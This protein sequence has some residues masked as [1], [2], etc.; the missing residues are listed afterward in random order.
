VNLSSVL[1]AATTVVVL[2]AIIQ[3]LTNDRS[4]SALGALSFAFSYSFWSQAVE[5]EVYALN[6]LFVSTICYLLLRTFAR[7][8]NDPSFHRASVGGRRWVRWSSALVAVPRGQLT[9]I[10]VALVYGLSLTHHRTMLLL[11]PAII[12]YL[13]VRGAWRLMTSRSSTVA[14]VAFLAPLVTIHLYIPIRWWQINGEGMHWKQF[15]DLVLGTQFAAALRWDTIFTDPNRLHIFLRTLLD[16]YPAP[17]LLLATL[18]I[19]Y[20]L[21]SRDSTHGYPAWREGL[22]LLVAFSAYVAFGLSYDVPDVSLFLIPSYMIIAAAAGIGIYALRRSLERLLSRWR[23]ATPQLRRQLAASVTL[24]VVGIL[25]L[26]LIWTNFPRVDRSE[27]R[28][29]YDWGQYVLQ[30]DLPAGSVL[31]ADSEK[32]APL[33]YLQRVEDARLREGRTVLLARF[34]P[35][36]ESTYHLRS[37]GPLVEVATAPLATLP[38]EASPLD[39]DF[40]G[41]VVLAG[42]RLDADNLSRADT[43]RVTLFWKAQPGVRDNYDVRLRVVGPT[44]HVWME[45]KGQP[46]VNGLYPTAAWRPGEIVSDF[47]ALDL[48][49]RLPPGTYGLEVGLFA[50]FSEEGLASGVFPG[51]YVTLTDVSVTS[52]DGWWP[53]IPHPLRANFGDQILLLG[54]SFPSTITA[55]RSVSLTLYWQAVGHIDGNYE[56][57]VELLRPDGMVLWQAVDQPLFEEYPTSQ[58]SLADVLIDTHQVEV[59]DVSSGPVELR[60]AL[61]SP[62]DGDYLTAVDGWL[63]GQRSE[64]LLSGHTLAEPPVVSGEAENLP[65]NFE[66]QILLLDYDIQNVQVRKGGAL[67]LTLTWQAL[68]PMDEDYTIFVHLLDEGDQ[69][70][71]QEDIG[72]VRGTHPTSAW[73]EAEVVVDPHTIWTNPEA[74]LGLYRVEVGLYLLRTMERLQLLDASGS[75]VGDRLVIDLMEIVP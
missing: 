31:L 50:P 61:R 56:E 74:P 36:L 37:L 55:G 69:I 68:A 16:Q 75:P 63:A 34:L 54:Y 15:T 9:I 64:V 2:H 25:P 44:G 49:G 41:K 62:G 28:A 24:T 40:A 7:G 23:S 20:L 3:K 57:V 73:T 21:W 8:T 19:A 29:A 67:N 33:H 27:A 71:G 6:A 22:F 12:V 32:M 38:P 65:A 60:I 51:G 59:P 4:A 11:A 5:A 47:H 42:Y 46:P 72:P 14:L 48:A 52:S 35:G 17:A 66:N 13:T 30:Q 10:A 43:L 70:W 53:T 45:T 1:F 18:G 39:L 58:W 26:G